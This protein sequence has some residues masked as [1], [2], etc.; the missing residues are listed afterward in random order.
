MNRYFPAIA[1]MTLGLIAAPVAG[2]AQ[3]G[4]EK[5]NKPSPS[6]NSAN[7]L[8][9]QAMKKVQEQQEQMNKA[10]EEENARRMEEWR[11]QNEL[12]YEQWKKEHPLTPTQ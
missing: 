5:L 12:R 9:A 7:D 6:D 2:H 4:S 10:V 8:N 3:E 11:K 1:L